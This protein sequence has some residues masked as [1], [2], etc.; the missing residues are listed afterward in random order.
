MKET[1][2][3]VF[4]Y[5]PAEIVSPPLRIK[6]RPISLFVEKGSKGITVL[7]APEPA[8]EACRIAIWT[9]ADAPFVRTLARVMSSIPRSGAV[10]CKKE[11]KGKKKS[12]RT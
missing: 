5:L 8:N 12:A 6:I 7:R 3:D 10:R 1:I 2:G 11:R 9:S 4:M